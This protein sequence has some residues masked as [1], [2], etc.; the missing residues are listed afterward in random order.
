MAARVPPG[1]PSEERARREERFFDL[2]MFQLV[3]SGRGD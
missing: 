2:D 3:K 1:H